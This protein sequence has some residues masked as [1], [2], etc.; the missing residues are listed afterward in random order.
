MT[1]LKRPG[2]EELTRK[3]CR[4]VPHERSYV[5]KHAIDSTRPC[6]RGLPYR[7]KRIYVNMLMSHPLHTHTHTY[8]HTHTWQKF[9]SI[10]INQMKPFARQSLRSTDVPFTVRSPLM[11]YL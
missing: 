8:T 5:C 7:T 1:G 6:R 4:T 2:V 9:C 10:D 11:A 3:A